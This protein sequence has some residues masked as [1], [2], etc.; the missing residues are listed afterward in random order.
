M[1][2]RFFDREAFTVEDMGEA[3]ESFKHKFRALFQGG[4]AL[5]TGFTKVCYGH[6]AT[7]KIVR[8]RGED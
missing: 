7:L 2:A 4:V 1:L 5:D 8:Q 3:V 6:L